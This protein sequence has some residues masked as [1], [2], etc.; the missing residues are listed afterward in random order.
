MGC[1]WNK[2]D[3]RI[4]LLLRHGDSR[5]DHLKRYVG[6][7][8]TLLNERGR[9]QAERLRQ[10][11]MGISFAGYYCSTLQRSLETARLIAGKK[12]D[13]V[14]QLPELCE[15]SMGL[16]DGRSMDEVRCSFPEEYQR[17]GE[18]PAQH[19]APGGETFAE[20]QQRVVPAFYKIL[21][22]NEGPLLIV[23]HAGVNRVLLAQLLDMPLE[24][25]FRLSQDYACLNIL[26]MEK[27]QFRLQGLNLTTLT[28]C[29]SAVFAE[30]PSVS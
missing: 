2:H 17:R 15:I 14:K 11:L 29:K 30:P 26:V 4:V 24:N 18:D 23:G 20:L 7:T 5:Q 3:R 16:W 19:A 22:E 27:G 1:E 9:A 6:H 25:L 12:F 28:G 8:D 13:K 10:E 21:E